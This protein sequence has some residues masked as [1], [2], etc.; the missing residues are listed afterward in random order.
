[1]RIA[2]KHLYPLSHFTGPYFVFIETKSCYVSSAGLEL[3][4]DEVAL[5]LKV[6]LLT[7][8]PGAYTTLLRVISDLHIFAIVGK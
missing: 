2:G 7:L 8:P 3:Y 1:M 6:I 5:K 4:V